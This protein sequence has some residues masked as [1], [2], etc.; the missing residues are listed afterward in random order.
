MIQGM[1]GRVSIQDYSN[2]PSF[3]APMEGEE[4]M[5]ESFAMESFF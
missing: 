5:G 4:F 2:L 1:Q 3:I